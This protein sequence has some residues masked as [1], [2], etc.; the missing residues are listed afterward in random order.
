MPIINNKNAFERLKLFGWVL[1]P[2]SVNTLVIAEKT[3]ESAVGDKVAT[4]YLYPITDKE[5]SSAAVLSV[6]FMSKG[7]NILSSSNVL[8]PEG[9]DSA[10][11]AAL[12][13]KFAEGID[14]EVSQS[15][16]VRLLNSHSSDP[17][18]KE[19]PMTML[20]SS[21]QASIALEIVSDFAK[22][23]GLN[24]D[25]ELKEAM[26]DLMSN[27]MHLCKEKNVDFEDVLRIAGNNFDYECEEE[28][29]VAGMDC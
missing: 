13:D 6:G 23:G 15:Y 21:D 1:W 29:D 27:M 16:A 7:R 8:I 25:I 2:D 14:R 26:C 5:S 17:L 3:Y 9:C 28:A 22:S 20:T 12:V 24:I 18:T 11:F 4:A 19:T 10:Q